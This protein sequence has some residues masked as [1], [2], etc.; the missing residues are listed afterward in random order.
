MVWIIRHG[1]VWEPSE[2]PS[3]LRSQS[4]HPGL[5]WD[6]KDWTNDPDKALRFPTCK[7]ALNA[8]MRLSAWATTVE[9]VSS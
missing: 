6:G 4:S 5:W 3:V 8:S 9:E 2:E 1:L 7:E